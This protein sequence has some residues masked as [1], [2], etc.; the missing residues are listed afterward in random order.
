MPTSPLPQSTRNL[1]STLRTPLHPDRLQIPCI[2]YDSVSELA[3]HLLEHYKSREPTQGFSSRRVVPSLRLTR[4]RAVVF[5][6]QR[7]TFCGVAKLMADYRGIGT[8]H[9]CKTASFDSSEPPFRYDGLVSRFPPLP[10]TRAFLTSY[11]RQSCHM[12]GPRC[13]C[14]HLSI[15]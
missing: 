6:S 2:H 11:V 15:R 13:N 3:T 7:Y 5:M 12:S 9:T 4:S 14:L 8:Y 1:L 10:S